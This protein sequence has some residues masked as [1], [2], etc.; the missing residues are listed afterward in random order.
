MIIVGMYLVKNGFLTIL[1][2]MSVM[3]NICLKSL[4]KSLFDSSV[5]YFGSI[6]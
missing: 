1:C 3:W 4:L 5:R 6:V 2:F